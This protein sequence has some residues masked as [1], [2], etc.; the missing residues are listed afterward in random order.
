MSG[1]LFA[2][3]LTLGGGFGCRQSSATLDGGSRSA[4]GSSATTPGGNG[5]SCGHAACGD[6]FFVDAVP[7]GDCMA[8]A[9]CQVGVKLVALDDFHVNDEFPY[10]FVADPKP[11][12]QFVGTDP[13]GQGVFS[14]AAGDW[15]KDDPKSGAM[16]VGFF[17]STPG[18][19]SISGTFKLSVCS[20]AQCLLEQRPVTATFMAQ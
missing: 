3:A 17:L 12:V 7:P 10:R 11:L 9:L 4:L 19:Y 13:A 14:K 16:A 5:K 1:A 18:S 6:H 15:R 2:L 8:G 20:G